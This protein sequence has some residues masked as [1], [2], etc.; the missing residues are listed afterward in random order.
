MDGMD[1]ALPADAGAGHACPVSALD[2]DIPGVDLILIG[3]HGVIGKHPEGFLKLRPGHQIGLRREGGEEA[4]FPAGEVSLPEARQG[5]GP[6]GPQ[7]D[8]PDAP[9]KLRRELQEPPANP[10]AETACRLAV[11]LVHSFR[12]PLRLGL[13]S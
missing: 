11:I 7:A 4:R 2:G 12:R 6:S 8:F 10:A 5:Q 9:L 3:L 13:L 1:P